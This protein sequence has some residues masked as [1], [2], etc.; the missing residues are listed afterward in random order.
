MSP[1]KNRV[2]VTV[3]HS[4]IDYVLRV[5]LAQAAKAAGGATITEAKGLW[6]DHKGIEFAEDVRVYNFWYNEESRIALANQL[7]CVVSTMHTNEEQCVMAELL[8]NDE[9]RGQSVE[10]Y[11]LTK[12]QAL[13]L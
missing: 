7:E 6:Y 5:F 10:C 1:A 9:L 2:S 13:A 11:F 4:C 12:G 8:R 3:P